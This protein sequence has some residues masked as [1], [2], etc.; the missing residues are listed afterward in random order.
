MQ[1]CNDADFIPLS[2]L[3]KIH[4]VVMLSESSL[5]VHTRNGWLA[6]D[7]RHFHGRCSICRHGNDTISEER[8]DIA[9]TTPLRSFCDHH[10][11][12]VLLTNAEM[13]SFVRVTVGDVNWFDSITG[14]IGCYCLLSAVDLI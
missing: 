1:F 5:E 3:P 14:V 10:C 8:I 13:T 6:N 4:C 9:T 2:E 11:D 7:R 12:C